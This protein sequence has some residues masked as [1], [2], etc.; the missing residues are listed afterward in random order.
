V[1]LAE[2][3]ARVRPGGRLVVVDMMAHG[4]AE[5]R[6]RWATCGRDS[7]EDRCAAGWRNAGFTR[8]RWHGCAGPAR[9]GPGA[10]RGEWH[11]IAEVRGA[12]ESYHRLTRESMS[13]MLVDG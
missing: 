11:G 9:E 7:T 10:V 2:A 12:H 3:R 5:Y 1:A 13:T 4:R 8:V 6:E